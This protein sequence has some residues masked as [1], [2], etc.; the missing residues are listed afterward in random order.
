MHDNKRGGI[1]IPPL[2][3]FWC[4][5]LAPTLTLNLSNLALLGFLLQLVI[6]KDRHFHTT[7][8]LA[9]I[10]AA[11]ITHRLIRAIAHRRNTHARYALC[12]QIRRYRRR[13]FFRERLVV[14]AL[15]G[16][17]GVAFDEDVGIRVL[18]QHFSQI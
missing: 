18:V 17:V 8:L 14:V 2:L 16:G 6:R 11:I 7:V 4:V 3:H 9:A 5:A 15:A 1:H 12:L 10:F 13:A